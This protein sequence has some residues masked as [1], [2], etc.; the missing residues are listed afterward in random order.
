MRCFSI[1]FVASV[2][3]SVRR[4][5]ELSVAGCPHNRHACIYVGAC[6]EKN[7]SEASRLA[8]L[9]SCPVCRGN[10]NEI[11][12][13]S[14]CVSGRFILVRACLVSDDDRHASCHYREFRSANDE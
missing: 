2:A 13:T 11:V 6:C 10:S 5:L 7:C 1:H 4:P 14:A 3:Q 8:L 12:S 9:L